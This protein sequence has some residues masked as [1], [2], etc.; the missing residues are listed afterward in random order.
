MPSLRALSS[1]ST[2]RV[3]L[4]TLKSMT[5]FKLFNSRYNKQAAIW[6]DGGI[7][8]F[9]GLIFNLTDSSGETHYREIKQASGIFYP[10]RDR[11]NTKQDPK[12]GC[13]YTNATF[14]NEDILWME[15]DNYFTIED[16][17]GNIIRQEKNLLG[18]LNY[19]RDAKDLSCTNHA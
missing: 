9:S 13:I 4:R 3:E 14:Y 12:G 5:S 15:K 2:D 6:N 17:D 18:S 11:C 10:V 19:T 8:E 7:Q 1:I 16:V